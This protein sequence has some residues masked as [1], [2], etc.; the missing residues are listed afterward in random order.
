[1]SDTMPTA[2]EIALLHDLVAL[3]SVNL[4]F[5][6]QQ[7]RDFVPGFFPGAFCQNINPSHVLQ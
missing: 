1:M 6:D 5:D 4:G 3:P 2:D 7:P